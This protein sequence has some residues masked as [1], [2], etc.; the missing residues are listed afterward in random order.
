[1]SVRRLRP[2]TSA[3]LIVPY[4]SALL[5]HCH[6]PSSSR[7]ESPIRDSFDSYELRYIIHNS[8]LN[9]HYLTYSDTVV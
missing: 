1:M 3:Y 2:I 6:S 5:I 4:I 9:T 8:V 7:A